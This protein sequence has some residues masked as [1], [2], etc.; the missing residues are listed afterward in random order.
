MD[1][2][3]GHGLGIEFHDGLFSMKTGHYVCYSG[4]ESG[5]MPFQM[6]RQP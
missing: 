5:V 1:I 4:D 2:L 3:F 6:L